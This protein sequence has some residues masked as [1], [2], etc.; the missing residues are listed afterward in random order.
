[1]KEKENLVVEYNPVKKLVIHSLYELTYK[2][3]INDIFV[4]QNPMN[5]FWC[6]GYLFTFVA[7]QTDG[8]PDIMKDFLNGIFHWQEVTY[9]KAEKPQNM[10]IRDGALEV[11][12]TDASDMYPHLQF[13]SWIKTN[14][15]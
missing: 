7:L 11:K 6:D 13:I 4:Y 9:C 1:M 10:I 2:E 5:L 8:N 15:K 12:I 14:K 3:F